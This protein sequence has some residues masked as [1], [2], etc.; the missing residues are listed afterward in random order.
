MLSVMPLQVPADGWTVDDLLEDGL[1]RYELVDGALLVTPPPE[2]RHDEAAMALRD[3]L[4][5]ALRPQWRVLTAAGLPLDRRNYRL[6]DVV[7]YDRAASA[8]GRIEPGDVHLAVEVMSPS[9]VSNDRVAKPVQYAAAGIPHFW[10][11]ELDP[12]VLVVH[13]LT[14]EAYE[15]VVRSEDEVRLEEPVPVWFRL[16]T[17]LE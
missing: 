2:L 5:A 6:P 11:L 9:S 14:G 13:R 7:V 1:R 17:L 12:L 8:R 4:H 3:L 16:G 15:V 10:R